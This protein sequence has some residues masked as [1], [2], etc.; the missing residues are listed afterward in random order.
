[1]SIPK[2]KNTDASS[3]G[4]EDKESGGLDNEDEDIDLQNMLV[5]KQLPDDDIEMQ[6]EPC[7]DLNEDDV[8]ENPRKSL[9]PK[10][11]AWTKFETT[12]DNSNKII[13]NKCV[14]CMKNVSAMA[15]RMKKHVDSCW[16]W[17]KTRPNVGCEPAPATSIDA[18]ASG[19]EPNLDQSI[20]QTL[21]CS[22]PSKQTSISNFTAR[23][24]SKKK[25]CWI[26]S[27]DDSYFLLI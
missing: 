15:D 8:S 9:R 19:K 14:K 18:P 13:S 27:L 21:F 20:T 4:N 17:K 5:D 12:R 26:C 16:M 2:T 24:A 11:D 22:T 6:K 23:V 10:S 7:A 25:K 1:L 3:V